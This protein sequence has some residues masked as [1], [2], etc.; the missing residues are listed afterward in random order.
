M[1]RIITGGTRVA[2][3]WTKRIGES[4]IY[5]ININSLILQK[6]YMNINNY[7]PWLL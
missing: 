1:R 3:A 5:I 6:D 7:I 2:G 4:E